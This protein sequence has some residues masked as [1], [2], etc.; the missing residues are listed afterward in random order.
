MYLLIE[1]FTNLEPVH[2][3]LFLAVIT[4][5]NLRLV[6]EKLDKAINQSGDESRAPGCFSR[7]SNF[8]VLPYVIQY[9]LIIFS[10]YP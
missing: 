6:L 5:I 2:A 3:P 9:F 10:F 7:S 4:N 8:I 1:K